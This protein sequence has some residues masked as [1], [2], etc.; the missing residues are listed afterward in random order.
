MG[1]LVN[2]LALSVLEEGQRTRQACKGLLKG[3]SK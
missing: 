1:E 3:H 2:K